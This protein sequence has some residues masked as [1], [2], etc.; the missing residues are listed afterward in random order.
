[1]YQK[2]KMDL[3]LHIIL[4]KQLLF[5]VMSENRIKKLFSKIDE[6]GNEGYI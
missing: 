3:H 5:M 4:I 6:K 2:N 1:M